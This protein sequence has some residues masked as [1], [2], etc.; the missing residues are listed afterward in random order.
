MKVKR[1]IVYIAGK[2]RSRW[3]IIG[4][5]INI[6]KARQAAIKMWK[7]GYTTIC[8]HLNTAFFDGKAPDEIWLEGD[9][10][11]LAKCHIVYMLKGWQN[12]TG[13]REEWREAT[14]RGLTV[15]F[16]DESESVDKWGMPDWD[17]IEPFTAIEDCNQI[18]NCKLGDNEKPIFH[19]RVGEKE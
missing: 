7:L 11:I 14:E 10:K 13:A 16:E 3:G 6:W 8:P 9:L 2:Y 18:V 17:K 5:A 12:S 15:I 4:R 19:A 1:Q